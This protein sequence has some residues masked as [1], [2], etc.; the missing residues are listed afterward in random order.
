METLIFIL[1]IIGIV[2]IFRILAKLFN[3]MGNALDKFGDTLADI[4]ISNAKATT[5]NNVSEKEKEKI[6]EKIRTLQGNKTDKEYK[7]HV[8]KEID[9]LIKGE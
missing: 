7:E 4:S 1:A 9:D 3:K 2:F 8:Q 6:R 5:V